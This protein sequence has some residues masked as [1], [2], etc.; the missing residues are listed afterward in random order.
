MQKIK[1][2]KGPTGPHRAFNEV[3][4]TYPLISGIA[5][6]GTSGSPLLLPLKK[7]TIKQIKDR[8]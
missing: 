7:G 8:V 6:S 2:I 1:T 3:N 4:A 5:M